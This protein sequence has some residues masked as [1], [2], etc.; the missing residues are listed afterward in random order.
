MFSWCFH[1]LEERNRLVIDRGTS[2]LVRTFNRSMIALLE[3]KL[4]QKEIPKIFI[5]NCMENENFEIEKKSKFFISRKN[6]G[7]KKKHW[8]LYENEKF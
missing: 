4:G 3:K 8:K 7:S 6:L 1:G 2:K 5:E